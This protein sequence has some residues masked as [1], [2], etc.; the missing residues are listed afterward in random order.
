[1]GVSD[2]AD[3][4]PRSNVIVMPWGAHQDAID[5]VVRLFGWDPPEQRVRPEPFDVMPLAEAY[6]VKR[7]GRRPRLRLV[8]A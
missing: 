1:M 8:V 5:R 2:R 7:R 3:G 4:D 6:P